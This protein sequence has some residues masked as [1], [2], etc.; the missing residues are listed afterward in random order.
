M[1]VARFSTA[2][3]A[4][5]HPLWNHPLEDDLWTPQWE[6]HVCACVRVWQGATTRAEGAMKNLAALD[7]LLW[8]KQTCPF[9]GHAW[10]MTRRTSW[11]R[12]F[13]LHVSPQRSSGSNSLFGAADSSMEPN[14]GVRRWGC[15]GDKQVDGVVSSEYKRTSCGVLEGWKAK[16]FHSH[17][18]THSKNM[19]VKLNTLNLVVCLYMAQWWTGNSS[20]PNDSW[21]RLE[22]TPV[23]P[24]K[25]GKR[26]IE[27]LLSK[28]QKATSA[29]EEHCR[30]QPHT[31][32]VA[33]LQKDKRARST[34]WLLSFL[35]NSLI[36]TD[37]TGL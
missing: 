9:S 33:L 17:K 11:W 1:R 35:C 4:S 12:C 37:G 5:L 19:W 20:R 22:L 24:K 6:A 3:C 21:G 13:W 23:R 10:V 16:L 30:T 27:H 34:K 36:D 7:A 18:P 2:V 14:K 28:K 8:R 32:A 29:V 25:R 26:S 31:V 15:S